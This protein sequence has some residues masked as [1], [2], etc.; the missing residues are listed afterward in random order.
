[1]AEERRC[2]REALGEKR[3][4]TEEVLTK[5]EDPKRKEALPMQGLLGLLMTPFDGIHNG[6]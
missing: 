1:M 2:K 6:T 3:L 4:C 5:K